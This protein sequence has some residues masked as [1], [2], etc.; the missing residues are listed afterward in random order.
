MEY[1]NYTVKDKEGNDI[2]LT[3][4]DKADIQKIIQEYYR[5]QQLLYDKIL[6]R[7]G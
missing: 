3:D 7:H 2:P 1:P 4:E 6:K 5:K